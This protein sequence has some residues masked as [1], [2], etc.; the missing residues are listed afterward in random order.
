MASSYS[1]DIRCG[2]ASQICIR[3]NAVGTAALGVTS[4]SVTPVAMSAPPKLLPEIRHC[5]VSI[6]G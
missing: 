1:R 2:F 3:G 5:P 4:S 6:D